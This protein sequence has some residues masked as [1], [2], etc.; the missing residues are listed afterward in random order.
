LIWQEIKPDN[1][2]YHLALRLKGYNYITPGIYFVTICTYNRNKV[3]AKIEKSKSILS[4]IGEIAED[5]WKDIPGHFPYV[6]LMD[7]IFMPNHLHG[8]I[9]LN[10]NGTIY[11]A[12][13]GG[14]ESFGQPLK[15]SIPTIIRTYKA[16]VTRI[17][18]RNIIKPSTPIWQPG[19]YE[20][21]I[22][23]EEELRYTI[24]YTKLN[25]ANWEIER[26]D[27]L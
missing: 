2:R 25:P 11:R 10:E 15:G 7:Y 20:H 21:V 12:S 27:I 18:N 22:R 5:C 24:N 23:N 13:T 19:Y 3:L 6:S 9:C 1:Y 8:L 16:A 14:K 17:I 4:K 26:N